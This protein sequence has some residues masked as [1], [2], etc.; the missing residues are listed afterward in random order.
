[1]ITLETLCN[2]TAQEVFDQVATHLL[3]Q[4]QK[5]ME[6]VG[7]GCAY[8]GSYGLKCAAGC[9]MSDNE[10]SS[11]MEGKRWRDLV[12]ECSVPTDHFDLIRQLQNIHDAREPECWLERLNDL[13]DSL[14]LQRITV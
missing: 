3:H 2:A 4:G 9:L 14:H 12:L 8:R 7:T 1:M 6:I 10:W 11:G 13:A 5:S